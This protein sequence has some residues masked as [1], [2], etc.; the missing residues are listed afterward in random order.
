MFDIKKWNWLINKSYQNLFLFLLRKKKN[1]TDK[2]TEPFEINRKGNREQTLSLSNSG[3]RKLSTYNW[4]LHL[5]CLPGFLDTWNQI[6][7]AHITVAERREDR[8]S[9]FCDPLYKIALYFKFS[10]MS[11]FFGF[12]THQIN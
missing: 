5:W 10:I 9:C 1:K 6:F 4:R 7:L 11:K 12:Y 3:I 8:N 2:K